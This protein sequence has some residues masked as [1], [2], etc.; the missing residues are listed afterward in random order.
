MSLTE[1]FMQGG[2]FM[3]YI[4]FADIVTASVIVVLLIVNKQDKFRFFLITITGLS[5]LPLLVGAFGSWVGYV[6]TMSVLPMADPAQKQQLYME[7]MAVA[8]IPS[9]FG[10]ISTVVVFLAG[11]L[12]FK[13]R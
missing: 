9:E 11:M 6:T 3:W 10:G 4:I 7:S 5:L 13:V 8:R 12:G 1:W 2:I